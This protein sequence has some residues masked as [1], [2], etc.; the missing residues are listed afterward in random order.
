[1]GDR[2]FAAG[3][4]ARRHLHGVENVESFLRTSSNLDP[5]ESL[6]QFDPGFWRPQMPSTIGPEH[7]YTRFGDRYRGRDQRKRPPQDGFRG[8]NGRYVKF[9]TGFIRDRDITPRQE[10]ARAGTDLY[11]YVPESTSIMYNK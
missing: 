4:E 11:I 2:E 6:E 10:E 1:M 9:N 7:M 3:E 8:F 5:S